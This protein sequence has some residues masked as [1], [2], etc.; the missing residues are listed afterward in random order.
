MDLTSYGRSHWRP[1]VWLLPALL[2]LGCGADVDVRKALQVADVTTGWLDAG[3]VQGKN[4]LVPTISF[5]LQNVS[6][7]SINVVQINGVFKRMQEE[8]EWGTVFTRVIG[9]EGVEPGG[10]TAPIVLRSQ[11]GYTGEQPRTEILQHSQFIDARVQL[12]AKHG[13]AAWVKLAEYPI[14]RQLLTQ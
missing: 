5:R 2:A 10:A 8:D 6:D 4:K 14:E 12:F 1:A 3:I 13:S 11:L 7:T 9:S